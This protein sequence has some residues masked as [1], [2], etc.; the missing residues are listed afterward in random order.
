MPNL[1]RRLAVYASSMAIFCS[2]GGLCGGCAG[3]M[4]AAAPPDPL[5]VARPYQSDAPLDYAASKSYP[6]VLALH[7]YAANGTFVDDLLGLSPTVDAKQFVYAYP[8]S[9]IGADGFR[10]WNIEADPKRA[11]DMAYL[12]AVIFDMSTRYHVDPK[13]VFVVGHSNGS[14]MTYR[15]GC[16]RADKVA[17]IVGLAGTYSTD[18]TVCAPKTPVSELQIIGSADPSYPGKPPVHTTSEYWAHLDGCSATSDSTSP[19]LDLDFEL[20]G[21]ET[22]VEKWPG[23]KS[24]SDVELWLIQGAPHHPSFQR[25]AFPNMLL[26]WMNAHAKQP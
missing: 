20:P 3:G 11:D 16:E 17:A 7:G 9:T 6:L 2:L 5:I 4:T 21:A 14:A 26:N 23:C 15:Y 25:P 13:R 19:P 1:R 12:D 22:T 10:S 8:D 18:P 24:G